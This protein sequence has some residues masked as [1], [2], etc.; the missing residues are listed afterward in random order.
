MI[1]LES[2]LLK[3]VS[4][5]VSWKHK[6]IENNKV[7]LD[8]IDEYH[9]DGSICAYIWVQDLKCPIGRLVLAVSRSEQ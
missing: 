6:C 5:S 1:M 4:E 8:F 9:P 3:N 2:K 7:L